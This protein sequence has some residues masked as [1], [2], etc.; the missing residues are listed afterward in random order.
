M[1]LTLQAGAWLAFT[2]MTQSFTAGL[3]FAAGLAQM[4]IW[5]LGKHR[6]YR[7]EFSTYPRRKAIVPLVL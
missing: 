7:K 3:F 5:A 6:N 2:I 1:L 4:S